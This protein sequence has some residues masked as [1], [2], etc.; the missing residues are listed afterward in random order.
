MQRYSYFSYKTRK[1]G[2]DFQKKSI[3]LIFFGKNVC[4]SS[5]VSK[6][7][8]QNRNVRALEYG[9]MVTLQILVLSFLVRILVLQQESR[10][11]N[12]QRLFLFLS[13][14]ILLS[15][16]LAGCL[17]RYGESFPL[18]PRSQLSAYP[19]S[20]SVRSASYCPTWK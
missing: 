18:P 11:L 7:A 14:I 13:L 20:S 6:F 12:N 15:R 16:L 8:S 10:W 4:I 5:K 2:K 19:S 1:S 17:R 9:V 3:F